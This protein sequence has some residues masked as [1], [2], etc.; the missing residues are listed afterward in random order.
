MQSNPSLK[1]RIL[2]DTMTQSYYEQR[3]L[4][5]PILSPFQLLI[6]LHAPSPMLYAFNHH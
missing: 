5:L 6:F 4:Y 3:V 1:L 2:R